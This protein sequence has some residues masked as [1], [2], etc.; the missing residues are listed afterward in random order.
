MYLEKIAITKDYFIVFNDSNFDVDGLNT[1]LRTM[2]GKKIN[3]SY[4]AYMK[5][6]TAFHKR[7]LQVPNDIRNGII[8]RFPPCCIVHFCIDKF[9]NRLSG[10]RRG[11]LKNKYGETY[12]PCFFCKNRS[13]NRRTRK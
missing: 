13:S 9:L 6:G 10:V 12:I 8:D 7:I 2:S 4:L 11:S 1:L 5:R 3:E